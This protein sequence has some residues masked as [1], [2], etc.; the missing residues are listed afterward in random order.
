MK[1][2]GNFINIIEP[3]WIEELLSKDGMFRPRDGKQPDSVEME[4][5]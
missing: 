1:Y 5:E 2:V 3:E 4:E